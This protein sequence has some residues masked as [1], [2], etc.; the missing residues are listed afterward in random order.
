MKDQTNTFVTRRLPWPPP[1]LTAAF[2]G[3]QCRWLRCQ[4]SPPWS[5]RRGRGSLSPFCGHRAGWGGGQN[6]PRPQN[7]ASANIFS[8][9]CR[10]GSCART[11]RL[12]INP[13]S[14][15][16][17]CKNLRRQVLCEGLPKPIYT[18]SPLQ[19]S[20]A[21]QWFLVR[22]TNC[23]FP[24]ETLLCFKPNLQHSF[25][26]KKIARVSPGFYLLKPPHHRLVN[27]YYSC[28]CCWFC[29][30]ASPLLF[31]LSLSTVRNMQCH[32]TFQDLDS[33]TS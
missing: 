14:T 9:L 31:L 24:W 26:Q 12:Y 8:F 7:H 19:A 25:L 11:L 1:C 22:T 32:A 17:F 28:F 21:L 5:N 15:S 29:C 20:L 13:T 23:I 3:E 10:T 18:L 27:F 2:P 16:I 30:F 33:S 6:M 4:A